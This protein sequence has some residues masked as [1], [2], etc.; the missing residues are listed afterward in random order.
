MAT[1]SPALASTPVLVISS[2][3][4][5]SVKANVL[6]LGAD[7]YLARRFDPADLAPRIRAIRRVAERAA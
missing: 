6:E 2:D 4:R 1:V 5:P 7:D 3:D